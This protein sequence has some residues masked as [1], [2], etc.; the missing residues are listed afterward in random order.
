[1]HDSALSCLGGWQETTSD[2]CARS[3]L[4]T[5]AVV[6]CHHHS[7]H[8][9]HIQFASPNKVVALVITER[10][11]N[12][13]VYHIGGACACNP[14]LGAAATCTRGKRATWARLCW[15]IALRPWMTKHD[16]A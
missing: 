16:A 11:L 1:M 13:E 9:D 14:L 7:Q 2:D 12:Q 3:R 10:L 8:V 15:Q 4:L 6:S 5:A